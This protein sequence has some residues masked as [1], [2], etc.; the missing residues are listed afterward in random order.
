VEPARGRLAIWHCNKIIVFAM[1]LSG[2]SFIGI[3]TF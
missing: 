3:G 1:G 2:V